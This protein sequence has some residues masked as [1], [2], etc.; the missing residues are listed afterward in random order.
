MARS[1]DVFSLDSSGSVGAY[2]NPFGYLHE[3]ITV[4][5]AQ[6]LVVIGTPSTLNSWFAG[7]AWRMAFCAGC[8]AHLGWRFSTV[9]PG[10]EP[11][12]FWGLSGAALI[13]S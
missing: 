12:E 7:Y 4:L 10:G 13:E 2:I 11:P 6:Q 8:G 5:E 3:V 9:A 1:E